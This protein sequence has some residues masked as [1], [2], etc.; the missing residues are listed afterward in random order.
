MAAKINSLIL[1]NS[2]KFPSSVNDC[3]LNLENEYI[4]VVDRNSR[5]RKRDFNK[6]RPNLRIPEP[7]GAKFRDSRTKFPLPVRY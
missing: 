3:N 1:N 4:A 2:K 6:S 5:Y 7:Y